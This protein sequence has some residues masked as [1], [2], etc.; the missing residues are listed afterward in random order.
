M[1]R[2]KDLME[3]KKVKEGE[4]RKWKTRTL[5]K[6]RWAGWKSREGPE[7]EWR[8]ESVKKKREE[9]REMLQIFVKI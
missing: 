6:T 7:E 4:S 8:K 1:V 5:M 9:K 2:E 3:K